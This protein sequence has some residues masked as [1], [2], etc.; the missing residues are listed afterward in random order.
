VSVSESSSAYSYSHEMYIYIDTMYMAPKTA[1]PTL[2]RA[3]GKC[4]NK[5]LPFGVNEMENRKNSQNEH[6]NFS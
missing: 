4:S 1:L 2:A 6:T 3:R 5:F